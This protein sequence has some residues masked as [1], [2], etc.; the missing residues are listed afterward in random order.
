MKDKTYRVPSG[1]D[2]K[3]DKGKP[4]LR[5]KHFRIHSDVNDLIE[6]YAK[7]L[8]RSEAEVANEM[9][10]IG[11]VSFETKYGLRSRLAPLMF[12]RDEDVTYQL[13]NRLALALE[14]KRAECAKKANDL[15][16]AFGRMIAHGSQEDWKRYSDY[17][18]NVD[19]Y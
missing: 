8:R 2:L 17:G 4:R 1:D 6:K 11:I 9:L 3:E 7:F 18:G 19:E 15:S 10:R 13:N 16:D 14:K 12:G 5:E